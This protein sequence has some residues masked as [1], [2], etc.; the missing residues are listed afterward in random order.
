MGKLIHKILIT[1]PYYSS[2]D[3]NV[4]FSHVG[5]KY[6]VF[7]LLIS[8]FGILAEIRWNMAIFGKHRVTGSFMPLD[9]NKVSAYD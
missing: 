9:I 5:E 8:E 7:Y 3:K 2:R 1:N 4:E 6:I